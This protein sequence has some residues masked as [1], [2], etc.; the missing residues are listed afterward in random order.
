MTEKSIFVR[1]DLRIVWQFFHWIA[2]FWAKNGGQVVS[3]HDCFLGE[4]ENKG[5]FVSMNT[6]VV[7][8]IEFS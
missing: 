4:L 1:V 7:R 5:P 6:D 2:T 3:V 8:T